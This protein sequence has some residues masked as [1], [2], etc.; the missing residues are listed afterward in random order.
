MGSMILT[1]LAPRPKIP[2]TGNLA[3]IYINHL[4]VIR[5]ASRTVAISLKCSIKL[6][7]KIEEK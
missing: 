3:A 2:L 7:A 1:H 4:N 5:C 6:N